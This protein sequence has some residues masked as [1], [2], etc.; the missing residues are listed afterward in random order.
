M[1]ADALV[2][3]VWEFFRRIRWLTHPVRRGEITP[4]QYEGSEKGCNRRRMGVPSRCRERLFSW[5]YAWRR[6]RGA[7]VRA[8]AAA[9][10]ARLVADAGYE[11]RHRTIFFASTTMAVRKA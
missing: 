5:H 1:E 7:G 10:A 3:A 9:R 2:D 4:L 8:G 11:A 6:G